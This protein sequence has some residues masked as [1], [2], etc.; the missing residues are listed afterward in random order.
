MSRLQFGVFLLV[1]SVVGFAG[2]AAPEEPDDW[3]DRVPATVTVNYKDAPV[4][5]AYVTLFPEGDGGKS[6]QCVTD[7]GGKGVLGS[8]AADDG[9]VPGSYKVT[10]VKEEVSAVTEGAEESDAPEEADEEAANT[11]SAGKNL[12]PEKYLDPSTTDL[13]A[14][15]SES[16][17]NDLVLELTD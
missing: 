17:D 7:A 13:T 8:Y 12:L 9:A 2:C 4:E 16:G 10:V 3:L 15:I 1:A 14:T 5:G 11:D 6:A